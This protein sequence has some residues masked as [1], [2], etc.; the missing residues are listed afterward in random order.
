MIDYLHEKAEDYDDNDASMPEEERQYREI[1][2]LT[3]GELK[4]N[5]EQGTYWSTDDSLRRLLSYRPSIDDMKLIRRPLYYLSENKS[6]FDNKSLER[7]KYFI[8]LQKRL[9]EYFIDK[10][11]V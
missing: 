11:R 3:I 4:V 1:L 9:I 2:R 7:E 6:I 5:K 8:S 10:Y